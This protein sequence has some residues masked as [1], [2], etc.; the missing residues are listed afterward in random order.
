MIKDELAAYTAN[1]I[2]R[3]GCVYRKLDSASTRGT[4]RLSSR[5]DD[6]RLSLAALPLLWEHAPP[7]CSKPPHA[8]GSRPALLVGRSAGLPFL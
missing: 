1:I 7:Q 8:S 3:V 4:I 2:K 6:R 5:S